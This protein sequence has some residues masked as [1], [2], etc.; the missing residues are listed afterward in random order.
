MLVESI[1]E[2]E[3]SKILVCVKTT[4]QLTMLMQTEFP[5]TLTQ[6]G[7]SYLYITAK[8]GAVIDGKKV[9]RD[10]FFNTLNKWGKEPEQE[11]CCTPSLYSL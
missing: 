11:V 8:T 6:M 2:S 1:T 10:E 3:S 4:R 5:H 9:R 7:Y